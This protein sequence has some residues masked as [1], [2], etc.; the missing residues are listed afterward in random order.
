MAY[1][2]LVDSRLLEGALS[3]TATLIRAKSGATGRIPWDENTGF[4]TAVA[5]IPAG[6]GGGT[7]AVKTGTVTLS[8]SYAALNIAHGCGKSPLAVFLHVQNPTEAAPILNTWVG[9]FWHRDSF[10]GMLRS[11]TTGLLDGGAQRCYIVANGPDQYG[12]CVDAEKITC[13]PSMPWYPATY[14]W[15]AIYEV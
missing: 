7:L 2:K 8:Q 12:L 14:D 15:I 5:A 13:S 9:G 4:A 10:S 6:D 3:A 1:D 11:T